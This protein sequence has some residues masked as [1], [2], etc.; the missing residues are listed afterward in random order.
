MQI[1]QNQWTTK[2]MSWLDD[3]CLAD[4]I[5]YSIM[6]TNYGRPTMYGS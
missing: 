6:K 2:K 5:V 4:I 3:M 1:E